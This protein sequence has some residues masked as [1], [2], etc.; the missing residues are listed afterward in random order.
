MHETLQALGALRLRPERDQR[1][2]PEALHAHLGEVIGKL[3]RLQ[4]DLVPPA[5]I[6][7]TVASA[8]KKKPKKT[9]ESSRKKD[10]TQAE[11]GIDRRDTSGNVRDTEPEGSGE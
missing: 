10:P 11:T 9:D 7:A 4:A 3:T 1:E 8:K 5:S 2:T 6:A